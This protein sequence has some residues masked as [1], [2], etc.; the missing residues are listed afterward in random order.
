MV[1]DDCGQGLL[2]G[3]ASYLTL[4]NVGLWLLEPVE[5]LFEE[6]E[7]IWSLS[8]Q[9]VLARHDVLLFSIAKRIFECLLLHVS[10]DLEAAAKITLLD[11][12]LTVLV[13]F[14]GELVDH[15]LPFLK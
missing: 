15:S 1:L 7:T 6:Y 3:V 4:V 10:E 5:V 2:E 14:V 11:L 9:V 12:V 13:V 8:D